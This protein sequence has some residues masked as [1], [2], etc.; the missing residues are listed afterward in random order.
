MRI[1]HQSGFSEH[2]RYQTRAVIYSNLI[3]AFKIM[4][5]IMQTE[6]IKFEH[7]KCMVGIILF[8]NYR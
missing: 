1:I 3:I 7:E 2:E 8:V 6:G 4:L 5:E